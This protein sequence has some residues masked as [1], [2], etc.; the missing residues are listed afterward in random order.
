MSKRNNNHGKFFDRYSCEFNFIPNTLSSLY[1]EHK[2]SDD[3]IINPFEWKKI[4]SK[5]GFR[6]DFGLKNIKVE[7]IESD[8][9]KSKIKK[10]II[11]FPKPKNPP[12][13]FYALLYLDNKESKYYTLELDIGNT[14]L[15][16]DGGIICGQKGSSHL[17]YGRQCKDDKDEFIQAVEDII[18]GKPCDMNYNCQNIQ[19]VYTN[20]AEE[21]GMDT[22]ELNKECIIF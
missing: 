4:L 16:K 6:Y 11:T 21:L 22:D 14:I 9:K 12:E 19:N 1:L 3:I 5:E 2:I 13:C 20:A 17:N 7:K 10:F 8:S 18:D 15:F